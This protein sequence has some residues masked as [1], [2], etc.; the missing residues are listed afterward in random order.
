MTTPLRQHMI[1]DMQV[2]N[3]AAATQKEYIRQVSRFAKYFN[4][5]P[6]LLGPEEVRTYQVDLVNKMLSWNSFNVA[7]SAL[8]FLYK[9]TLHVDWVFEQIPYAKKPRKRPLILSLDE[10]CSFIQG[11]PNLKYRMFAILVYATGL[12]TS[13]AAHL[14]VCDIDSKRMMIRVNQ[15]KWRTDRDVP[16]SPALLAW[17][18]AYWK[19]IRPADYLFPSNIPTKPLSKNSVAKAIQRARRYSG[20]SKPVTL[21]MMRHSFATH[22]LESGT[23]IRVIQALL[24]H[25]SLNTTAIY[26]HVSRDTVCAAKSPLD[27]LPNLPEPPVQR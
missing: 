8:R 5:S 15:G 23:N 22:L 7:V 2:R 4:K 27:S 17:L 10:V 14:R 20:I 21:R 13:E 3:Y 24:G 26:T 1:E 12:R 25:R 19:I 16:L 18:R 6:D 11:I 9:N